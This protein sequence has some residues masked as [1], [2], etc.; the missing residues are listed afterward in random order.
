MN[1]LLI[2]FPNQLFEDKYINKINDKLH[3]ILWEHD[4]FFKKFKY[5]KMKLT[6][7]VVTMQQYFNDLNYD[8]LYIKNIDKNHKKII[9]EYIKKNKIEKI[10]FFNPI[11][12]ELI[13]LTEQY[14]S[15]LLPSPYFLNSYL[16][17]N[18]NISSVRH[19]A[20]YKYQ[21]IKLKIMI[22]NKNKP[23]GGKWSFDHS[24]RESFKKIDK[25]NNE[26][27]VF[28]NRD[29]QIKKAISYVNKYFPD[30]YGTNDLIDFIYPINHEEAKKWLTHFINYK[31]EHF[32][33]YEDALSS[34]IKFGYHSLLSPL[35]NIGLI[36]S[37]DIIDKIKDL[38]E[39]SINSK[40]GFI[41][42]I[43]GWREYCYLM[44]DKFSNYMIKN[45]YINLNKHTIPLKFWNGETKIPII[46]DIIK[47]INKYAYSHHI[48][49][50]MCIGNFLILIGIKQ[51]EIYNWFQTMYID[52]YDV[53]MV[54]NVYGM[55]L[56]AKI[57][58]NKHM[59]TKPY[60]C[61]SNYLLKMSD[62]KK[63]KIEINNKLYEWT[64]IFDS[65]YY[66]H[67]NN[68]KDVFKNIYSTALAVKTWNN[69]KNQ[70]EYINLANL[71]IKW[72]HKN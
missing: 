1:I 16:D 51:N 25:I 33:K 7:H 69:K 58:N 20:F 59:M 43:I 19:D 65:L 9:K 57:E 42:Q 46:D 34:T 49:R 37:M 40:E 27:I 22:N 71:Y 62:Y 31:L 61:S 54:P 21:R 13:K 66:N 41:R 30:N 28:K 24:N 10:I 36:T 14:N 48:E 44:Y 15:E 39:F 53:F 4:Y 60:L 23:E 18:D 52:A 64:D 45:T 5:H 63:S 2:L 35:N 11:E 38:K 17:N 55:L 3:V 67:I 6:F 50:L 32:G 68:Y 72:I 47:K 8:K 29:D 56:Y 26:L 12:K 70:E